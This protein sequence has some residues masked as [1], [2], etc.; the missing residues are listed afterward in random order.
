M[1]VASVRLQRILR[2]GGY[3][4]PGSAGGTPLMGRIGLSDAVLSSRA[5][6]N[7]S[8]S[9]VAPEPLLKRFPQD[10]RALARLRPG[11]RSLRRL[12]NRATRWLQ[13]MGDEPVLPL[14]LHVEQA[15]HPDNRVT[16]ASGRDAAGNRR[17]RL[18]WRWRPA[19]HE[20]LRAVRAA[21]ADGLAA[22]G[23]GQV[24]QASEQPPDPNA[25]HHAGTTRMHDDP[26]HGVVDR[27]GRAHGFENLYL[28]GGS[29]F[30][31]AGF[32]NPTLT[33]VALALRLGDHL[34][35]GY[36]PPQCRSRVPP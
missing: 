33:V 30:P 12:A 17:L 31:T 8:L 19:D 16:L 25:H 36:S 29:V 9:V 26:T 21:F 13:R 24:R 11:P 32:A 2:S 35:P 5:L 34:G 23:V 27:H 15:P 20:R 18:E 6:V 3:S 4:F 10:W 28:T 1:V 14:L 7:A 22:A